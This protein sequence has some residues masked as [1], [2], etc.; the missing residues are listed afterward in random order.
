MLAFI[1]SILAGTSSPNILRILNNINFDVPSSRSERQP[2]WRRR[3]RREDY[4]GPC[5]LVRTRSSL[6]DRSPQTPYRPPYRRDRSP[7]RRLGS[8]TGRDLPGRL[9]RF[10][11][12]LRYELRNG[13]PEAIK[14]A[15]QRLQIGSRRTHRVVGREK[16]RH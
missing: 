12:G 5:F 13:L 8:D 2:P 3:S 16:H 11:A 1:A 6:P 10:I 14:I 7:C 15:S 9:R 4:D